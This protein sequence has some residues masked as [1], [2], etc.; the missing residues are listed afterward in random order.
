LEEKL[1]FI[2]YLL[3]SAE[4]PTT[5]KCAPENGQQQMPLALCHDGEMP[6]NLLVYF[7]YR[8]PLQDSDEGEFVGNLITE[9]IA[10]FCP[11][12]FLYGKMWVLF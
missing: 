5:S 12:A 6:F 2:R 3:A 1:R 8:Q 9:R 4:M 10:L 11:E 7:R